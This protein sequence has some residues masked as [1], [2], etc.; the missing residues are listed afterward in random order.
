MW[1]VWKAST[2]SI[3]RGN[4]CLSKRGENNPIS[5]V[6]REIL[7][8]SWI[9]AR[10]SR[11]KPTDVPVQFICGGLWASVVNSRRRRPPRGRR[12]A[13][14][15][16]EVD[17]PRR[18]IK[19]VPRRAGALASLTASSVCPTSLREPINYCPPPVPQCE[20]KNTERKRKERR[21]SS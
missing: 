9:T 12:V 15:S 14:A 13:G 20:E 3:M 4:G 5:L 16:S 1:S 2:T 7:L 18:H 21:E 6:S 19:R 17:G 10:E 11:T 8:F